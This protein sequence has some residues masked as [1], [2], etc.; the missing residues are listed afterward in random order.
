MCRSAACHWQRR[1]RKKRLSRGETETAGVKEWKRGAT[2]SSGWE[3]LIGSECFN[4]D[5]FFITEEVCEEFK[6]ENIKLNLCYGL[7]CVN[8]T[9][10]FKYALITEWWVYGWH[11]I[12][13]IHSTQ[14]CCMKYIN[15]NIIQKAVMNLSLQSCEMLILFYWTILLLVWNR[16]QHTD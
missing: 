2:D 10:V 13:S 4:S 6:V 9:M 11:T 3:R 14:Q 12:K 7:V 16:G 1:D 8:L 5:L 15:A